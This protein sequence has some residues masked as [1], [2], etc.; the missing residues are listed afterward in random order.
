MAKEDQ[1]MVISDGKIQSMGPAASFQ[2][3]AGAQVLERTGCT[4]IP[5]LVGMHNHLYYTASFAIQV[6]SQAGLAEPGFFL[7][8]LPYSAPRLYLAGGVPAAPLSFNFLKR[9]V[10]S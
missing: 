4:V 3:P 9:G 1:A 8:E 5:G 6:G 2:L 7:A 10:L